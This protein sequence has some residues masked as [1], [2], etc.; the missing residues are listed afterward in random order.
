MRAAPLLGLALLVLPLFGNPYHVTVAVN[1]CITLILTLSLDLVVGKSGQF[2]LS[3]AAFF[4]GGAYV[5][6]ILATRAGLP[7]WLCLPAA[8]VVIGALG[9]L[10]ALPTTRLQGL[11]LAVATLAFSFFVEVVINEGGAVTGGGYG[12]QDV[13]RLAVS[14]LPLAGK[15]FYVLAA[16]MLVAVVAILHNIMDSRLGRELIASRDN[17]DSAAASGIDPRRIRITV[18]VIAAALAAAAG[19]LHAAYHRAVNADLVSPEWTFIWFFMVLVGGM[20]S[21]TG[22]V[23]GTVLLALMPELL[24]FAATDTIL[25]IGAL[26]ILVTL[27]APRGI[28]GL[29][30]A[31]VRVG[32]RQ[33]RNA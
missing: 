4:G 8:I 18:L 14:G 31:R 21:T 19:W 12:I 30:E 29:L 1:L 33:P 26:M 28:G 17:P 25:W 24:G 23:L 5:T 15:S 10:L 7:T 6:A 11:Y 32:G 13:P 22:V 16:A 27:F 9:M 3:H 20:G 2:H